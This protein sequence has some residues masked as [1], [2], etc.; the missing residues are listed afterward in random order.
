MF[1]KKKK[2]LKKITPRF[3]LASTNFPQ[4]RRGIFDVSLDFF[5]RATQS[6]FYWTISLSVGNYVTI[7]FFFFLIL[8]S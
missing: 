5:I 8:Y 4:F 3:E 6:L 7:F 2:K 1:D